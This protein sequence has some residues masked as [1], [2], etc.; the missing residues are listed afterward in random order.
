M[1]EVFADNS[2][3]LLDDDLRLNGFEEVMRTSLGK[4]RVFNSIELRAGEYILSNPNVAVLAA[5]SAFTTA[6]YAPGTRIG[7][8]NLFHP[9][10]VLKG[11][12][13]ENWT[14]Q[15]TG[16]MSIYRNANQIQLA[17]TAAGFPLVGNPALGVTLAGAIGGTGNATTTPGGA[18]YSAADFKIARLA[19]RTDGKSVLKVGN[20]ELPGYLD[21]QVSRNVGAGRLRD[22]MMATASL[23]S[24]RKFGEVRG[25]YQF[26]IKDANSMI[27][28]FTDDDLGTGSGVNIAV[29]AF[30]V[31]VGLTRFLQWQNLFFIQHEKSVSNP[32]QL[33]FVPLQRGA[34]STF[35]YLGQLAFTF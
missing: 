27:S 31:D 11:A 32:Q 9:G 8:A 16:D 23:G 29:H 18:L 17:S 22:A 28:Q 14:H 19:Y 21:F 10:V 3:F 15:L 6:G 4:N 34:N 20:R 12:L 24:A 7:A 13:S 35:R 26:A 25:L 2:R 33:F 1:E 30:R 5:N